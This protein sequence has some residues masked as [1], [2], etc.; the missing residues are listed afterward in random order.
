M[1]RT[2]GLESWARPWLGEP[3]SSTRG[4]GAAAMDGASALR[5]FWSVR[6]PLLMPAVG[7]IT[8]LTFI[9]CFNIFDLVYALGGLDGGPGGE[10]TGGADRRSAHVVDVRRDR[11]R[12]ARP[13][14]ARIVPLQPDILRTPVGLPDSLDPANYLRA[15]ETASI[16]TYFSNSILV[17]VV[18]VALCVAVSAMAAYA[19]S[20][21]RFRGR[22]VL[23]AFF[24]SG[25]M[26]PAK[27]G[28]LPVFYMSQSIGL[29]DAEEA[30]QSHRDGVLAA[31]PQQDERIEEVVPRGRELEHRDHGQRGPHERQRDRHVTDRAVLFAGLLIALVPLALVFAFATKQIIA[32]LTAGMSP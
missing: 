4:S 19:L 16:S 21:W 14:G 3:D 11:L 29:I 7:V 24:L 22:A 5:T 27:L 15:W 10:Q 17:T 30:G 2:A 1:L 23:T 28:L 32:G 25:L 18:A 13:G 26:I 12:A 9:G 6:F 31:V 20:R 8:V